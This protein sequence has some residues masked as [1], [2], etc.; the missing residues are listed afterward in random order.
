MK[1]IDQNHSSTRNVLRVIGPLILLVGIIFMIVGFVDFFASAGKFRGPQLFWCF[2]AGMP[3][4][5]VGIVTTSYGFMGS[6]ARYS[7][8]EMAPVAKDTINYMAEGTQDSVRTIASALE[9]GL[10]GV[11]GGQKVEEPKV[12]CHKCNHLVDEDS[13][14][15]SEC[16]SAMLKTKSC[17]K[18]NELNDGDARFCDN[19]G[20]Q[21]S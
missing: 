13:R 10:S 4:L 19:C 7:A 11:S 2:F 12:R 20:Q 8:G 14:F 17:P 3:L 15:C 9:A 1:P 21:L 18:C 6:V 16:G 5:F